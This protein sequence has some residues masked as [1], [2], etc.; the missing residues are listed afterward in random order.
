MVLHRYVGLVMAGFLVIVSLTGSLI[1]FRSELD[2]WLNPSLFQVE[3]VARTPPLTPSQLIARVE[4]T[5]PNVQAFVVTPAPA[6]GRSASVHVGAKVGAAEPDYNQVF[7][8]PA[9]GAILGRRMEGAVRFN[10]AHLMPMIYGF[11]YTLYAPFGKLLLGIIALMWM[12]DCFVGFYL[13][14]PRGEPFWTKWRSSWRIKRGASAFRFNLDL[15]RATSLWLWLALFAVALSS[16]AVSLKVEIFRPALSVLVPTSQLMWERPLP[17]TPPG[18]QIDWNAATA[19]AKA[20]AGRR[21]WH[22]PVR[23]IYVV[24]TAGYYAFRFGREHKAGF[25]VSHIY[26]ASDDGRILSVEEAGAGK[27][28]DAIEDLMLPIH[29]GQVFGLPGRILICMTGLAVAMLSITGVYIWWKKRQP[30]IARARS[31]AA[32][33]IPRSNAGDRRAAQ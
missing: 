27:P 28:G 12:I 18:W 22:E 33:D 32:P 16:V 9:T 6:A 19:L 5:D 13:T 1:V 3:P 10:R 4:R 11:H 7:L 30:R 29:S 26:V 21:G 20:E 14:L 25:G 2:R 8:D 24:P 15:H 17:T 23:L 31:A